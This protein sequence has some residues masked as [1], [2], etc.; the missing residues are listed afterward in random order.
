MM[1]RQQVLLVS[2][3]GGHLTFESVFDQTLGQLLED[4]ALA[5]AKTQRTTAEQVSAFLQRILEEA[6][7][8]ATQQREAITA[9]LRS[10]GHRIVSL[11][12]AQLAAF[13]GNM[14]ELR[15]RDGDRVVALSRR[16]YDALSEAQRE[17]LVRAK[18]M[19]ITGNTGE[20]K[21]GSQQDN[22]NGAGGVHS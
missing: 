6:D 13:A 20:R 18:L 5:E 17:R 7:P 16:A 12:Y 11:D 3:V 9:R 1:R 15:N 8:V 19:E 4:A 14:L 22:S 21:A 2:Q 10:S